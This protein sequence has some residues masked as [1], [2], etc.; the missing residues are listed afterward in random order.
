MAPLRRVF[1][2][3]ASPLQPRSTSGGTISYRDR[4]M[5]NAERGKGGKSIRACLRT[6]VHG[7][8]CLKKKRLQVCSA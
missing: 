1:L 5:T 3:P 2:L 7:G 6:K 4:A 8:K